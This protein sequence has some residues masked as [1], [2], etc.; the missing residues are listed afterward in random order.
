MVYT[1]YADVLWLINL[2]L[3]YALL[4]A[5]ARFGAFACRRLRLCMAAVLG[6][7]YGV[8]LLYPALALL[9][10]MPVPVAV[11]VVMLLVGFGR[12]PLKKFARL[13]LC[14]YLLAFVM[15]G[16]ALAARY[17]LAS[18]AVQGISFMWLVPALLVALLV[19]LL[20]VG[21]MR[22]VFRQSG[23]QV[24][25]DVLFDG[26]TCRFNCFL[27][28]GNRLKEPMSGRPVLL[29]ELSAVKSLLPADLYAELDS[30]LLRQAA[31]GEYRPYELLLKMQGR[32]FAGQLS[33]IP[34]AGANGAG[35]LGLA[36][37]PDAICYRLADGRKLCP[38]LLPMILPVGARLKGIADARGLIDPAAVFSEVKPVAPL[39]QSERQMYEQMY[40]VEQHERSMGA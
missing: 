40:E 38:A 34:Y 26:K 33:V 27:D 12:M 32:R 15:G 14:F 13:V 30:G 35:C 2:L 11:S 18:A 31:G 5:V 23:L 16:A 22:Q 8:G 4:A 17:L 9:Y 29:A 21:Y 10:V 19:A 3:D 7:F 24:A 37:L 6:A 39:M 20:G 28:S 36:L 25:V 1:V